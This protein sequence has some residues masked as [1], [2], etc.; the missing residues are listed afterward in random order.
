MLDVEKFLDEWKSVSEVTERSTEFCGWC[1]TSHAPNGVIV[2]GWFTC[3]KWRECENCYNKRKSKVRRQ[4]EHTPDDTVIIVCKDDVARKLLRK[5]EITSEDYY[6]A[7]LVDGNVI[8][9]ISEVLL[10]EIGF[11]DYIHI[12]DLR[13]R[14]DES[15]SINESFADMFANIPEKSRTSGSLGKTDDDKKL[16]FYESP[17]DEADTIQLLVSEII[18]D[19]TESVP[20]ELFEQ[21]TILTSTPAH[22]HGMDIEKVYLERQGVF[23]MLLNQNNISHHVLRRSIKMVSRKWMENNFV[24]I[25]KEE[26]VKITSN[27]DLL[28]LRKTSSQVYYNQIAR[29]ASADQHHLMY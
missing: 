9:A 24:F 27:I 1:N 6:R 12:Y 16:M 22:Q 2:Q 17:I 20:A 18:T 29:Y 19:T 26:N 5:R 21:A 4:L 23:E 11:T 8:I 25:E 14:H 13:N 15:S 28:V 10:D 7:P 3:N